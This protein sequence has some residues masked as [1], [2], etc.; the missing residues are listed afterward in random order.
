[1]EGQSGWCY[2]QHR[3]SLGVCWGRNNPGSLTLVLESSAGPVCSGMCKV[4]QACQ[5]A[6]CRIC[7]Q[8]LGWLAGWGTLLNTRPHCPPKI[9]ILYRHCVFASVFP[10]GALPLAEVDLGVLERS[11]WVKPH[12]GPLMIPPL[13]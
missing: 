9:N 10:V 3:G 2:R 12:C 8:P 7:S 6:S 11:S 5:A 4:V 1:M 13:P